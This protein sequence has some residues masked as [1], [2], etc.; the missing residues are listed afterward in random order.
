MDHA[1]SGPSTCRPNVIK[2]EAGHTE[3]RSTSL[4]TKVQTCLGHV[5]RLAVSA[6]IW[7]LLHKNVPFLLRGLGGWLTPSPRALTARRVRGGWRD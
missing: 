7:S 4:T 3:K 6:E 1:P 5:T 2:P